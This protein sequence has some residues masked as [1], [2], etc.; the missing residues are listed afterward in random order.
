MVRTDRVSGSVDG[1]P[2]SLQEPPGLNDEAGT[3]ESRDRRTQLHRTQPGPL[4]EG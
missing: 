1:S 4:G 3:P 2:T